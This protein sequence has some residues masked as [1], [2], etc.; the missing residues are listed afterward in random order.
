MAV[1]G[2]CVIGG[3]DLWFLHVERAVRSI[4]LSSLSL[5][6]IYMFD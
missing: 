5:I 2:V 3:I 4:S 1:V 6:I